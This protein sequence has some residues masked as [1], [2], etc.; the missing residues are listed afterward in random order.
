MGHHG[1][2]TIQI[3][4]MARD[5]PAGFYYD[6]D[7]IILETHFSQGCGDPQYPSGAGIPFPS[8]RDGILHTD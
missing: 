7:N 5:R 2:Q 3:E 8:E 6:K 1:N 4:V